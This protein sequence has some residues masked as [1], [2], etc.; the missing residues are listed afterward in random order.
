MIQGIFKLP[1]K[2][3]NPNLIALNALNATLSNSIKLSSFP[4]FIV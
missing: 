2:R 1:Q 4:E 3:L